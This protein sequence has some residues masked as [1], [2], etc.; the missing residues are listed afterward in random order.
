MIILLL[1]ERARDEDF[2]PAL[3]MSKILGLSLVPRTPLPSP[4]LVPRTLRVPFV[5]SKEE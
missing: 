3:D 4:L 1:D 2:E 5:L